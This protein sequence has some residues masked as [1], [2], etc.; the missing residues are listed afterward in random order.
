MPGMPIFSNRPRRFVAALVRESDKGADQIAA[1]VKEVLEASK[2]RD[3]DK[4]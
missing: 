1:I 3:D 4:R 2:L